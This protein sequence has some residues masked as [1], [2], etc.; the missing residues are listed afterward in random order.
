M[1]LRDCGNERPKY[2]GRVRSLLLITPEPG[3]ELG[4]GLLYTTPEV[5]A[6]E[7]ILIR[8]GHVPGFLP[9]HPAA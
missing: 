7:P 4:G 6:Y 1:N 9:V 3:A 8:K 5:A 2:S